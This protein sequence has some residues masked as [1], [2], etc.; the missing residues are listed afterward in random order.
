[1]ERGLE[2]LK[3]LRLTIAGRLPLPDAEDKLDCIEGGNGS[4]FTLR[5]W[6]RGDPGDERGG[7]GCGVGIGGGFYT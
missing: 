4:G 3:G 2:Q 1:M 6:G 5:G 7:W